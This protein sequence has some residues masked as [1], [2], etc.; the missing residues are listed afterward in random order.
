MHPYDQNETYHTFNVDKIEHMKE[1]C[2]VD[3]QS[4]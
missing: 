2:W 3:E 1:T 4:I